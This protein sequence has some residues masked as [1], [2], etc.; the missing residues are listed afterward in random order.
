MKDHRVVSTK[1]TFQKR[2]VITCL[3][4]GCFSTSVWTWGND[5]S[6]ADRKLLKIIQSQKNFFSEKNKTLLT[7]LELSRKAQYLVALY[8]SY[9]AQN[10]DD[11]NALILYGKFLK[12]VGQSGHAI[13]FFLKADSIN[14]KIAVVKQ[15]IAN[16]LVENERP[17]DA[18]PFFIAAVEIDSDVPDYHFH[19]GNFLH[20]FKDQITLSE[21]LK[22]KSIDA[23][24]HE[25]FEKAAR[26]KP[27]S[28]DY[29]LRYAQSFF[30]HDNSNHEKALETWKKMAKDFESIL[31]KPET[32][33]IRLCQARVMLELN[34]KEEATKLIGQVSTKS[35][36]ESKQV[37]LKSIKQ[38]PKPS[39]IKKVKKPKKTGFLKQLDND[40]HIKRLKIVTDKL[41]EENLIQQLH[42]DR[43]RAHHD[44]NG[45]IR[46]IVHLPKNDN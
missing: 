39:P 2:L 44:L 31:S 30:D 24:A 37:L 38:I 10:P 9:L 1:M 15:Q 19:L 40:P 13:S 11:T 29:R 34:Q 35:L 6:L 23:F 26:Q 27:S 33:Y 8:E 18:L 3:F 7:E 22:E 36:G 43:V 42:A 14:P 41:R 25:C 45:Q 12:K 16:Y 5:Y 17:L 4:F 46:L 28:F 32:D 21:L 20:L